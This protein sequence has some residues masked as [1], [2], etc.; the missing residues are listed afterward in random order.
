MRIAPTGTEIRR[1]ERRLL[2]RFF[3]LMGIVFVVFALLALGH[4]L[5]ASW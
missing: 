2:R 3:A 1:A 4:R 5:L